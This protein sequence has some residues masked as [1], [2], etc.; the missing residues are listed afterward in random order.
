[1]RLTLHL[2]RNGRAF[3][4]AL[5][6]VVIKNVLDWAVTR[7]IVRHRVPKSFVGFVRAHAS[8]ET[9]RF[10]R[11]S[12]KKLVLMPGAKSKQKTL[13]QIP[14]DGSRVRA[15]VGHWYRNTVN[16]DLAKAV[17]TSSSLVYE[18]V[19]RSLIRQSLV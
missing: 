8:Q 12:I 2:P 17:K 9:T 15:K 11:K 7:R 18:I 1:M 13:V 5:L 4:H 6:E 19:N 10:D 14:V 3:A 16:A